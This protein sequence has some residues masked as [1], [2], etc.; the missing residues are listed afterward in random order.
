MLTH[1]L[2]AAFASCIGCAAIAGIA[3]D[4]L[5]NSLAPA[6]F[7]QVST[8]WH[9][10]DTILDTDKTFIDLLGKDPAQRQRFVME[11]SD[12]VAAEDVDV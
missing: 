4:G 8:T 2:S 9:A 11:K 12:Q 3:Y 6:Q 7:S 1:T 10:E 5:S